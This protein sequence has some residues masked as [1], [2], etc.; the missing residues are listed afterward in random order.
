MT[1]P[2]ATLPEYDSQ[3]EAD[4]ASYL[5]GLLYGGIITKWWHHPM[6]LQLAPKTSYQPDFMV[7]MGKSLILYEV[8]GWHKNRR[9]SLTHLKVAA[10]LFP[11]F[12]FVLVTRE[13]RAWTEKV[14]G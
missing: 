2:N 12:R 14:I 11:C 3:L 4:Y 6:R 7:Q 1:N 10:S 13:R 8:K 5:Q 9:D